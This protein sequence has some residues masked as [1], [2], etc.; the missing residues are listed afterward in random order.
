MLINL[1]L[2]KKF[3]WRTEKDPLGISFKHG[4]DMNTTTNSIVVPGPHRALYFVYVAITFDFGDIESVPIFYHNV[5]KSHPLLPNTIDTLLMTKYGGSSESKRVYTSFLCG[6][7]QMQGN[8]NLKTEVSSY[9]YVS[10]SRYGSYFGMFRLWNLQVMKFAK[11]VLGEQ[12]S[13]EVNNIEI[14]GV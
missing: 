14:C 8:F 7:F 11:I 4:V 3:V 1:I 12:S 10:T 2:D 13:W 9:D 5:T 6:T